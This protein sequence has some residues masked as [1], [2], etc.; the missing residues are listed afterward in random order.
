MKK[1]GLEEILAYR[2]KRACRRQALLTEYPFPLVCLGLNIPGEYK[3]FP[4][5]L[6]SFHDELET[7]TLALEAE[8]IN[9][10]H[11]ERNE[12]SAGYTAYFSVSSAPKVL[13]TI[14]LRVEE[15]HPLGRLFDIDVYEP[16]GRKLSRQDYGAVPRPCFVCGENGFLCA[17]SRAH[18]P[19]ELRSSIL[20]MMENRLRQKLSDLVSSA[21]F[22]AMMSEAA[23]TP[24][25]GLIDRANNGAH[26]DMDFFTLIDSAAALLPWFRSCALAGFD[27]G[28][29][30][31]GIGN[32]GSEPGALLSDPRVLFESLRPQGRAA[33]VMMK[34]ASGGVNSY[35]GYIF[36]FG[37]LSAAYGKLYR[38]EEKP[39][40]AG[41]L[42]FSKEMT[43]TL[44][45]DFSQL[46]EGGKSSN[47]EFSHGE[48]AY[49]RS[50]IQGIRGEVSLGFP[51]VA[52]HA[53]PL[54]RSLLKEGYSLN[55]A[56][57]A[58]LIKLLAH[59]EDTNII[60]RGG[61]ETLAAI[62]KDLR[63]FFAKNP[64]IKQIRQKAVA[65]D[66]EFISRNLS[67]GGSAD[68]LGVT[69]FLY[70]LL[71]DRC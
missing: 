28:A 3:D 6:R 45:E 50:G 46:R 8:G 2:E 11:A 29:E 65:L 26:S 18:P 57:V 31:R 34:K 51:S 60:H 52:E 43:R 47:R 68:L 49:T 10:S 59:A 61:M 16:G 63:F 1:A 70:R 25:P 27:S 20:R 14:A 12:E 21:A 23:I 48:T 71:A 53:L 5:A 32:L 38:N 41:I 9:V 39:E 37:I 64:N 13:K 35:R 30:N 36:S 54:L 19:G 66:S 67:P 15:S 7:F 4:W 62:Q 22:W 58:V 44:G 33:E 24:K 17:R 69:L 42:E 56:G 40:L 55:D